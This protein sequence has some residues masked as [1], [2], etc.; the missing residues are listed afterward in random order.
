MLINCDCE[1]TFSRISH[2]KHFSRYFREAFASQLGTIAFLR[3]NFRRK[4]VHT[5]LALRLYEYLYE[6]CLRHQQLNH[7]IF[8]S[9][10]R[11]KNELSVQSI[12][13]H[14]QCLRDVL[15]AALSKL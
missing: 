8:S 11:P 2:R 5:Y 14:I 9:N 1:G 13:S 3:F 4:Q 12:V 7:V 15:I 10:L 6:T